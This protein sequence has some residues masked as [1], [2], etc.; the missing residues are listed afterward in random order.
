M[1]AV[2]VTCQNLTYRIDCPWILRTDLQISKPCNAG[3]CGQSNCQMVSIRGLGSRSIDRSISVVV[4]GQDL[5]PLRFTHWHGLSDKRHGSEYHCGAGQ[6]DRMVAV[7]VLKVQIMD[8]R[9]RYAEQHNGG[10]LPIL[11]L[12][13]S[14]QGLLQAKRGSTLPSQY[15]PFPTPKLPSL[16]NPLSCTDLPQF[17]CRLLHLMRL[18]LPNPVLTY[19]GCIRTTTTPFTFKSIAMLFPILLTAAFGAR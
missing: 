10:H 2:L 19:P 8:Y 4:W 1:L 14:H 6:R 11:L 17:L 12:T 18:P 16:L 7:F 15:P 13:H 5:G 3:S 9:D